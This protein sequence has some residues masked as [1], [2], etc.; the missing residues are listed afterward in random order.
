MRLLLVALTAIEVLL[1]LSLVLYRATRRVYPGFDRWTVAEG[2]QAC[3]YLA[4]TLRGFAPDLISIFA[5]NLVFPIAAV[6]RL[7]GVHRFFDRPRIAKG[8]YALPAA[9]LVLL[10]LGAYAPN[11]G[12]WR[13][14]MTSAAT[15]MPSLVMAALIWRQ[16]PERRRVFGA[17]IAAALAFLGVLL[18]VR[19]AA[20]LTAIGSARYDWLA[21]ST[22]EEGA[23]IAIMAGHVAVT[24]GFLMLNSERLEHELERAEATLRTS[25]TNLQRALTE[26]KTLSGLLPICAHCKKV[27]DDAGYWTQI[28]VYVR[29]RSEAEFSHGICPDCLRSVFPDSVDQT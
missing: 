20:L 28:E 22:P 1:A 2:L 27:R 9:H 11:A 13:G 14:A 10:L 7:D 5:A 3:G 6:F 17:T 8:W 12:A 18:V 24:V 23:F 25:V 15:A 21:G 29:D 26:V 16:H 4:L 19:A